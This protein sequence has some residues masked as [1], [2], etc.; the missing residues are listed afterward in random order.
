[1]CRVAWGALVALGLASAAVAQDF[2]GAPW[3]RTELPT[4]DIVWIA[5]E[6]IAGD[7]IGSDPVHVLRGPGTRPGTYLINEYRFSCDG[8]VQTRTLTWGRDGPGQ[9]PE[10]RPERE[11][12]RGGVEGGLFEVAC[13]DAPL[14]TDIEVGSAREALA[15]DVTARDRG[16]TPR[17]TRWD[18]GPGGPDREPREEREEREPM[19][20]R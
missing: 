20:E 8:G 4:G 3:M 16:W 10:P 14:L 5:S 17:T 19:G 9:E 11:V 1:M 18:S 13:E 2:D 12:R 15:Y 7:S 6:D